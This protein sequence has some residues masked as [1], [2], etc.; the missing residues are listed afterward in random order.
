MQME[1][2]GYRTWGSCAVDNHALIG[3]ARKLGYQTEREYRLLAWLKKA[4]WQET[5]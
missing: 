1:Q 4:D 3:L 5:A 2:H